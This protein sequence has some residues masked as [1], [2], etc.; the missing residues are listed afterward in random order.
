MKDFLELLNGL[1]DAQREMMA[2]PDIGEAAH[3]GPAPTRKALVD[4]GLIEMVKREQGNGDVA[5]LTETGSQVR[6]ALLWAKGETGSLDVEFKPGDLRRFRPPADVPAC[7][8]S[9]DARAAPDG[10]SADDLKARGLG[11]GP[12]LSHQRAFAMLCDALDLP[13]GPVTIDPIAGELYAF[14]RAQRW[15]VPEAF[16]LQAHTLNREP[17]PADGW[18]GAKPDVQLFFRLFRGIGQAVCEAADVSG[19]VHTEAVRQL[20]SELRRTDAA[21]KRARRHQAF[22]EEKAKRAKAVQAH[23]RA[24]ADKENEGK[25]KT[26]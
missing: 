22:Q 9:L 6:E 21:R 15:P 8:L 4:R 20:A 18:P 16:Y 11:D 14:G 17:V 2:A 12:D 25:G 3:T 1:S 7:I 23:R 19:L 5:I 10:V 24:G 13:D 26:A